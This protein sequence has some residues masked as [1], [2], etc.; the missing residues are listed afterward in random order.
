MRSW[1]LSAVEQDEVWQRWR[2]E[3]LRL[4]A[5]RLGKRGPSL[6]GGEHRHAHR[7]CHPNATSSDHERYPRVNQGHSPRA[8]GW[9]RLRP[10]VGEEAEAA[11]H[12]RGQGLR[13]AQLHHYND[14]V[15]ARVQPA[16]QC[17]AVR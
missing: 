6:P 12:A 1:G 9:A 7:P 17:M 14:A 10:T 11:W 15:A 8:V 16:C 4:I 5:R 13:S 2:S 3:S